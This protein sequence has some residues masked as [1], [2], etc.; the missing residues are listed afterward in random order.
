MTL[1]QIISA[2]VSNRR[3]L[4]TS[5]TVGDAWL[6]GPKYIIDWIFKQTIIVDI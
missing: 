2:R 3:I 1:Y 4:S 6:T 5:S